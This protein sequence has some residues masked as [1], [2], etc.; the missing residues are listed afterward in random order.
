MYQTNEL[1][2]MFRNEYRCYKS[3]VIRSCAL[4]LVGS[5]VQIQRLCKWLSLMRK[6]EL[7]TVSGW[8]LKV[9]FNNIT[10]SWVFFAWILFRI[11]HCTLSLKPIFFFFVYF[12]RLYFFFNLKQ[13]CFVF[14]NLWKSFLCFTNKYWTCKLF[15]FILLKGQK[16]I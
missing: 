11:P 5:Q 4:N 3:V 7:A 12:F 6:L 9:P 8:A 10:E 15:V 16:Y 2:F 13:Q 1:D 14:H